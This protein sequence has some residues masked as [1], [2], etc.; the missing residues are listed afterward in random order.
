MTT[1]TYQ[2]TETFMNMEGDIFAENASIVPLGG[3]SR[4]LAMWEQD[5]VHGFMRAASPSSR[6]S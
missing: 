3:G 6:R 2:W 5:A 1:V 4:Y